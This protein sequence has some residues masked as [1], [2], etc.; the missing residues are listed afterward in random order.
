MF[1]WF[2]SLSEIRLIALLTA[3]L[4]AVLVRTF[5]Q[6]DYLLQRTVKTFLPDTL[7]S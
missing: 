7:F 5:R 3:R 2:C 1:K 4:H 6:R